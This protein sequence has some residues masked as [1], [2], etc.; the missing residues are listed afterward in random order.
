[1]DDTSRLSR[2]LAESARIYERLNFAGIRVVA[3][4]QGIDTQSEQSDVL[5]TLHSLVDSLYVMSRNWQR[6]RIADLKAKSFAG[7][8]LADA[9]TATGM[10]KALT[11]CA[12]K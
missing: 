8:T 12:L 3:V 9:A 6:R 11:E 2:N 7:C 5:V 4:S 10:Y 1:M